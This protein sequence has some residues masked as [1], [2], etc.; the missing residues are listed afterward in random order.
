M[1]SLKAVEVA[2]SS[3]LVGLVSAEGLMRR[4]W[5]L[6]GM[7]RMSPTRDRRRPEAM[8]RRYGDH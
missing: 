3:G 2:S 4:Y 8:R 5:F 6:E 7:R 1:P